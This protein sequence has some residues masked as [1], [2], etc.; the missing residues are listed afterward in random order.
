[1]KPTKQ[2]ADEFHG[3]MYKLHDRACS[4]TGYAH[5]ALQRML[6]NL[7]GLKTA[8]KLINAQNVSKGFTALRARNKLHLTTEAMIIDNERWHPLFSNAELAICRERLIEH[9]YR[10]ARLSAKKDIERAALFCTKS[11]FEPQTPRNYL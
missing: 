1:M 6:E 10:P 11:A 7:G 2:L 9:D 3:A 5:P 4:E 8:K